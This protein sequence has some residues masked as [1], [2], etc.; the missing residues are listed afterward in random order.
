MALKI[1]SLRNVVAGALAGVV[2]LTS[3]YMVSPKKADAQDRVFAGISIPLSRSSNEVIQGTRI[4]VGY[5]HL[6]NN[7]NIG[8]SGEVFVTPSGKTFGVAGD[9]YSGTEDAGVSGGVEVGYDIPNHKFQEALR[10]AVQVQKGTANLGVKLPF[11]GV[12]KPNLSGL[13]YTLGLGTPKWDK[14]KKSN[15]DPDT[16]TNTS[17]GGSTI[18]DNL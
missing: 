5:A 17:G 3:G 4:E 11:S 16:T 7:G 12:M 2:A 10:A 6:N 15:S 8:F 18:W 13:E 14:D 1:A 9:I